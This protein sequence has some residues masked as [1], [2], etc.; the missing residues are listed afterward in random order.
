M[1]QDGIENFNL[2]SHA[3]HCCQAMHVI[4]ATMFNERDNIAGIIAK[5]IEQFGVVFP[6]RFLRSVG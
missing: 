3:V 5:Y 4:C 2:T 1:S 6:R